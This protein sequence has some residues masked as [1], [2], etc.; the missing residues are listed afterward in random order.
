MALKPDFA[1]DIQSQ[2]YK[3]HLPDDVA[4]KILQGLRQAGLPASVISSSAAET[5]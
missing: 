2:L 3:R 4:Q 5:N 1:G